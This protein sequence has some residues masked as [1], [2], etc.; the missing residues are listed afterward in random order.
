MNVIDP[1]AGTISDPHF[2]NSAADA[3]GVTE[4]ASQVSKRARSRAPLRAKRPRT[5]TPHSRSRKSQR[6]GSDD[7]AHDRGCPDGSATGRNIARSAHGSDLISA[8]ARTRFVKA[9]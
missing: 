9:C 8:H 6:S 5:G 3:P 7:I 2:H 1:V 4:V